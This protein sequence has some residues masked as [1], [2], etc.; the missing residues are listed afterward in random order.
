[1]EAPLGGPP[2]C[3][4]CC[5]SSKMKMCLTCDL[6]SPKLTLTCLH[7]I[8]EFQEV[9]FH[10]LA[11]GQPRG[12]ED[13][14]QAHSPRFLRS[15]ETPPQFWLLFPSRPAEGSFVTGVSGTSH[16]LARGPAQKVEVGSSRRQWNHPLGALWLFQTLEGTT[17]PGDRLFHI[18]LCTGHPARDVSH[19]PHLW[20]APKDLLSSSCFPSITVFMTLTHTAFL[21]NTAA[22]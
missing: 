15:P 17:D 11:G 14:L 5:H 22:D 8:W 19:D 10:V 6:T 1:M 2:N 13:L 4:S 20:S 18:W 21:R 9:D 16:G 12:R 3:R 7:F